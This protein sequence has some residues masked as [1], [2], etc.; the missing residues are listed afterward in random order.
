MDIELNITEQDVSDVI[1]SDPFIKLKV[2]NTAL[3]RHLEASQ[4]ALQTAMDEL[5]VLKGLDEATQKG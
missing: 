1:N 3:K 5:N 2:Q 4:L